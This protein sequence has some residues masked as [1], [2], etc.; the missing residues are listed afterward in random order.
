MIQSNL[1]SNVKRVYGND[2]FVILLFLNEAFDGAAATQRADIG[3]FKK[4]KDKASLY[5]NIQ[6]NKVRELLKY[7]QSLTNYNIIG[8]NKCESLKIVKI[9]QSAAKQ[10]VKQVEGSTTIESIVKEKNLNK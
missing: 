8:N 1:Y 4:S 9:G 5:G 2:I 6:K 7:P 10:P 3:D